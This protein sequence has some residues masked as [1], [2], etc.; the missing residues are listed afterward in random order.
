MRLIT[1][2]KQGEWFVHSV[3]EKTKERMEYQIRRIPAGK[4]KE[5]EIRLLG[6]KRESTWRQG[7][8]VVVH[9]V[10]KSE[11][12]I[13]EKAA[14]A[15]LDSK[16]CELPAECVPSLTDV[17]PKDGYVLLDGHWSDA[18][19]AEAFAAVPELA[20]WVVEQAGKLQA[21]AQEDEAGKAAS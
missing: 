18:V 8:R 4:A 3:D 14:Y 1:S 6:H 15:L 16:G 17:T 21:Q 5:I 12:V 7:A 10:V 13:V 20:L 11:A 2:D 9:D 19:K